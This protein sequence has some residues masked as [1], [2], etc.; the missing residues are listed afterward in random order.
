MRSPTCAPPAHEYGVVLRANHTPTDTQGG[1]R[2]GGWVHSLL[3]WPISTLYAR[4]VHTYTAHI[5]T[6]THN[7][8][9]NNNNNNNSNGRWQAPEIQNRT[10]RQGG[11]GGSVT[12]LLLKQTLIGVDVLLHKFP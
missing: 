2:M 1:T 8:N 12:D 10:T 4:N 3:A 5:H 11:C 6:Q 7:N 9:N